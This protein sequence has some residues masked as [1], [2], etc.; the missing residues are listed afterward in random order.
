MHPEAIALK[1]QK[2]NCCNDSSSLAGRYPRHTYTQGDALG[3]LLLPL[4]GVCGQIKYNY[5]KF[6]ALCKFH[7]LCTVRAEDVPAEVKRT[8]YS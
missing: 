8:N 2:P 5:Q 7:Y 4:R 6:G 3:L 1:G